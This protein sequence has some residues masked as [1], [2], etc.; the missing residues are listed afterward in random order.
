MNCVAFPLAGAV[1]LVADETIKL[2]KDTFMARHTTM[3]SRVQKT[4]YGDVTLTS[5]WMR[6]HYVLVA[7]GT[8]DALKWLFPQKE[9][10][11]EI[12]GNCFRHAFIPAPKKVTVERDLRGYCSQWQDYWDERLADYSNGTKQAANEHPKQPSTLREAYEHHQ[13]HY[14][15][16]LGS[17][18]KEQY[19]A[20]MEEWFEYLGADTRLEDI[21][22]EVILA[23]RTQMQKDRKSSNTTINGKVS[24]LKKVLNMAHRKGWISKAPWRDVPPL[25]LMRP[26]VR[27]WNAEQAAV[28]FAVAK[29]DTDPGRATL[30]VVLGIYL[31]LRKNEA[32]HVRWKDLVLDRLHPTTGQPSP[33]CLIQQREGFTTKTYENRK[34]P[35]SAEAVRLLRQYRPADAGPDDYVLDAERHHQKRG[36]TKRV[37]RYDPV[38]V[39]QR[40]LKAAM[41][42]G[43]PHIEFKEMRHSF[44]CNCLMK[45]HSVERVARWLGHKDPRMVRQHYAFLLDYE[46]DTGL[47]FLSEGE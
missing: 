5:R 44:A 2:K 46:E 34:V 30:M 3:P 31:G 21:T 24:T 33:I 28:A 6:D 42:K 29:E 17:R 23:A 43:N 37:Y 47:E 16:L 41:A 10:E 25:R 11:P 45:G 22:A 8:R 4:P 36:G 15:G 35:I 18:T 7:S 40:V 38:K 39:W 27:F 13:A 26:P 9:G 20:R 1:K 14:A 32:V 19:P 12:H